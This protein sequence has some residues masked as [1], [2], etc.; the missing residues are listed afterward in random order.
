[1]MIDFHHPLEGSSRLWWTKGTGAMA[2]TG[3]PCPTFPLRTPVVVAFPKDPRE[4]PSRETA[5]RP[6]P[7]ARI[8]FCNT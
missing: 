2:C 7:K 5:W 4:V 8:R 1:M 6:I 3:R